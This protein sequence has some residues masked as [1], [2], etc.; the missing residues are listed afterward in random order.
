[1]GR[2]GTKWEWTD[3]R[4]HALEPD[5]IIQLNCLDQGWKAEGLGHILMKIRKKN[6]TNFV[7]HFFDPKL[8]FVEKIGYDR[9]KSYNLKLLI[10]IILIEIYLL[11]KVEGSSLLMI[12]TNHKN[13]YSVRN[14]GAPKSPAQIVPGCV[15]VQRHT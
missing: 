11:F 12:K 5:Q 3:F 6:S 14:A 1:M 10:K 2:F 15:A 7:D 9:H 8:K 4:K 13:Y